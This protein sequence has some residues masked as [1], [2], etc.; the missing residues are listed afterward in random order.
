MSTLG[1]KQL[2]KERISTHLLNREDEPSEH[3]EYALE[4]QL[5]RGESHLLFEAQQS[6]LRRSL[7]LKV[8][9]PSGGD[10][11]ELKKVFRSFARE[12]HT[13]A[14][15]DHP[16]V[17]PI[18]AL[19]KDTEGHLFF[20][21]RALKG[22]PWNLLLHPQRAKDEE[23]RAAIKERS[24]KMSWR[25]HLKIL[26]RVMETVS[27]AHSKGILHRDLKPSN[28]L[29]GE[30]SEVYVQ[31]WELAFSLGS[32]E[33]E[34]RLAGTP[35]YMAPEMARC[36]LKALS[37]ASDVYLLGATLYEILTGKP[38]R[39]R[40]D[41][42]EMVL[43]AAKG[44][45]LPIE[46]HSAPRDMSPDL[47]EVLLRALAPE[48]SARY[49]SVAEFRE[50]LERS[51]GHIESIKS[52]EQGTLILKEEERLLLKDPAVHSYEVKR[53]SREKA[54][55]HY[56]QLGACQGF[57]R[58]ALS[59]WEDNQCAQ[60]GLLAASLLLGRV[61]ITQ[62]ELKLART[63]EQGLERLSS[64]K[65][66]PFSQ[67]V[68]SRRRELRSLI[69]AARFK[70]GEDDLR[71]KRM[72][73]LSWGSF[74]IVL[75]ALGITLL[76]IESDRRSLEEDQ[77][78]PNAIILET[79]LMMVEQ[80]LDHSQH[81]VSL[82]KE[83]KSE[84]SLAGMQEAIGDF[85][86]SMKVRGLLVQSS[87]KEDTVSYRVL[88]DS[89]QDLGESAPLV[90]DHIPVLWPKCLQL[91]REKDSSKLGD[92]K[93]HHTSFDYQGWILFVIRK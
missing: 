33:P 39:P 62:G 90:E 15:L 70:R 54:S 32:E 87:F 92:G 69:R 72:K 20:S 10:R 38:P 47:G 7:Q 44:E 66:T 49:Q 16:G 77:K 91:L 28:V 52:C 4:S 80:F 65:E 18:Y 74:T 85:A 42:K 29:I 59:L 64:D 1:L 17:A 76:L 35:R 63:E 55:V 23:Q 9:R 68:E 75:I 36:E 79:K 93:I 31:R 5:S 46:Q 26:F 88:L 21:T 83:S 67:L 56:K 27:Y 51:L 81:L 19:A 37:E 78:L 22:T 57:F 2:S 82:Y 48:P 71:Q 34:A 60:E 61:A 53:L 13:L 84:K 6:S 40:A 25:D 41:L 73:G 43:S 24:E 3:F 86:H 50:A 8:C 89:N 58:L 30:F 11:E 45:L 14:Q 12:A